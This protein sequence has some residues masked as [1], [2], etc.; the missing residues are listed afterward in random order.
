MISVPDSATLNSINTLPFVRDAI[1]VKSRNASAISERVQDKFADEVVDSFDY[2][3][4]LN[5][6]R[7][8]N[9]ECLHEA[10]YDGKG[11]LMAIIDDGF[12]KADSNRAFD[13]LRA[14]NQILATWD[15]VSNNQNVYDDDTHGA[16]V[17]SHIAAYV[18]DSLAGT[19]PKA[20]FLL[21]RS[22]DAFT[23]N[24]VEEYNWA[25]AAEFADSAGAD[26]ISS[27]LGYSE[28][29]DPSMNHTY[30]DM[31]GNT[32]PST[33]AADIAAAKGMLV[34]VA[35][36]NEG[37]SFWHHITAPSDGDSVLCVGAVD[38]LGRHASFSSYGPSSDGDIK[39]NI[40]A[41]GQ[42]TVFANIDGSIRGGGN[43]TSF[44]TPVMAGGA[45]CLWQAHPSATNMDVFRALEQ[46]GN[47]QCNPN[48][49]MGYGIPDLIR[50]DS[51]LNLLENKSGALT[52]CRST[53]ADPYSSFP[54]PVFTDVKVFPNPFSN[55]L[56]IYYPIAPS[57]IVEL[58][59]SIGQ[60]V[61]QQRKS[62]DGYTA[63]KIPDINLATG[64]YV[65]RIDDGI[66]IHAAKLIKD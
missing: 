20:D 52:S 56:F 16:Y 28:F 23:E 38:A 54:C 44:A 45:A 32:C 6:I 48:D 22:E 34:L 66:N 31:D 46:S 8:M 29:N 62:S 39:P 3:V 50:A 5:Q 9:G 57:V 7:L 42:G 41:K 49:T 4:S 59:N 65:L 64:L 60:R 61:F 13:S 19:A 47:Y 40:M 12:Y 14:N 43:G 21:L 11:I 27:S 53:D 55:E 35:A 17:L 25:A 63:L 26:I 51:L 10:G 1:K 30:A 15:F 37:N 58:Y 24:I 2:G 36:G 18:S 33:I